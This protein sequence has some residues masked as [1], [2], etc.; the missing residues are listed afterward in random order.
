M[1]GDTTVR[2]AAPSRSDVPA[3]TKYGLY[4]EDLRQDF[5]NACGY[6]GDSDERIDRIAFHIDHFAP[7]A[8]FPD[9]E[10]V[11]ANLVYACRFCNVSK[12]DHWIGVDSAI[13]N[14]GAK[15]FV[16]PCSAEYEQH[17]RRLPTGQIVGAS[18]LGT[19]IVGRLK[20][21]LLRHELLWNARRMRVVQREVD[22]LIDKLELRGE[23]GSPRYIKLLQRFRELTKSIEDYEFRANNS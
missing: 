6:C 4:R 11:Y 5:L 23:Q 17:L 7:K 21:H 1:L 12:A 2:A 8:L 15:G 9:L 16:D 14:D 3:K 10:L 20:L 18:D 19:Y 13:P 22:S